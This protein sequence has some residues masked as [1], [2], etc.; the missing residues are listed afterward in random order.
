[1]YTV[2][3]EVQTTYGVFP[4]PSYAKSVVYLPHEKL[5]WE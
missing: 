5:V 2:E 1:M 3:L 4:Q